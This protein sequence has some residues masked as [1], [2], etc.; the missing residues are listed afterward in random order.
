MDNKKTN[1]TSF[2][3]TV[4]APTRIDII[5]GTLDLWPLHQILPKCATINFGITLDA[6]TH[7]EFTSHEHH[8]LESTDQKVSVTCS[9]DELAKNVVLP[10]HA[11]IIAALWPK[12]APS[13]KLKT[14]AMSPA[15]AGLG[16]SSALAVT[17][18]WAVLQARKATFGI[19]LPTEHQLVDIVKD[20]ESEIIHAPTGVQ[21]YW[22]AIK[23]GLNILTFPPGNT[24]VQQVK[25]NILKQLQDDLIV[26]FSGQSRASAMNNWQI[27]RDFF[28]RKTAT[29]DLLTKMGQCA[30]DAKQAVEAGD[31]DELMRLSVK[32]WQLRCQL[33][34]GI[35]TEVTRQIS[36]QA[37]AAGAYSSR[38][39]GA[40][41]GGVMSILAKPS[42]REH[43]IKEI[44]KVGGTVLHQ[45]R[46]STQGLRCEA[47]K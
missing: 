25:N 19:D 3:V 1:R 22:G 20:I 37:R 11:K 13:L 5:G 39:C 47:G 33:W 27:Y 44:E 2:S 36:E 24:S 23:G 14:S 46:I 35:E 6:T 29:I 38:V 8:V 18:A 15:G 4:S 41:G 9:R 34:P 32:E 40:G 12:D 16:G 31:F 26:C 21:D 28:D 17:I 42:A 10:L 45:A 7:L 43:V 30:F